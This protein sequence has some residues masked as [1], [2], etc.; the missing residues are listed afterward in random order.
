M[1]PE[2]L[3]MMANQIASF[4]RAQGEG[5]APSAVADHLRKFW[6]PDM[7]RALVLALQTDGARMDPVVV[8]AAELLKAS[9]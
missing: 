5:A 7:R 4:F 6:E 9:S 3:I 2:K 8:R 1:P